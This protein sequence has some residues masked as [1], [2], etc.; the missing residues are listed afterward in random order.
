MLPEKLAKLNIKNE[1]TGDAFEVLFNPT[2]YSI[3]DSSTWSDQKRNG[4]VPELHY[5]GGARKKL[6]MELFFDT[7]ESRDDVREHTGKIAQ[8]MEIY[9]EEHRPPIVTITWGKPTEHE[10]PQVFPFKAVLESLK[11]Q[12]ILFLSDGT[13]VRAK[14]SVSFIQFSLPKEEMKKNE[15]RSSDHTRSYLVK[16][17]D[18]LTGIATMFYRNPRRWRYIARE[19]KIINPRQLEPG[20][21]LTIP[22][23]EPGVN[24]RRN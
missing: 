2:E 23:I 11:Q 1:D 20:R 9:G 22:P 3:D 7:Y 16:T 12:F 6:A 4:Q 15:N 13:P 5:T 24:N 10:V 8:L 19:N 18:T 21:M 17:G 14:L